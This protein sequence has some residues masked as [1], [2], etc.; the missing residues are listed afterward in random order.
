[1]TRSRR[2]T[3]APHDAEHDDHPP[4]SRSAQFT[5]QWC[6]LQTFASVSA[7]HSLPPWRGLVEAAR[8]R[9]ERPLAHSLLHSVHCDQLDTTQSIGQLWVPHLRSSVR[10]AQALPPCSAGRFS[11]RLRAC[12]PGPNSSAHGFVQFD[13]VFH[14]SN[15]Q[16]SGHAATL[17]SRSARMCGHGAPLPT[18]AMATD[19]VRD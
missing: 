9:R 3:P 1:M 11:A 17:Q 19:R 2:E 13:H 6:V 15:S 18:A 14:H 7:G 10:E 5:G 8:K 16:S 4:Q 12:D